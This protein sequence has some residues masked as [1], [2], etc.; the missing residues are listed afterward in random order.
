MKIFKEPAVPEDQLLL[1]PPNVADFV[2]EDAAVRIFSELVD[3][4]DCSALRDRHKGGGA[5]AY[6]PVMLFKVLVF[7]LSEGIRSSR[8]LARCLTYDV[9]FMYL[10]RMSRPDFRTIARFRKSREEAIAVLFR[11]TVL[12]AKGMGLVLL[13]HGSVDGTKLVSQASRRRYIRADELEA[14]LTKLD[15][16]IAQLL[17]EMAETDAAE[18]LE[19]G[20]GPG[21]GVPDELRNLEER[22]KRLQQAKADLA[23]QGT[24]AVVT[25]DPES[26]LMKTGDGLRPSYNAQAVVDSNVQ[27]I[28]AADVTQEAVDARQLRPM[29]ERVKSTMEELPKQVTADGGYWSKDSLDYTQEQNLDAYIA[30]AGTKENKLAGWTYDKDRDVLLSPNEEEYVYSTKRVN[31]GRTYRGYRCRKTRHLKWI[32]ND[33]DQIMRMR[34]KVATQE[35]KAIYRKRQT[36]V[37]PVFGHIKGPLGLQKLLL[38]GLTGARI[39]YLLACIAH[40]LGK[41]A[42]VRQK[43][44]AFNPA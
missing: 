33:A 43:N 7:G 15:D 12:L 36:I 24:K 14:S 10:V 26:R 28:V 42:G 32:N 18:D 23:S 11:E 8:R 37:E 1:L 9:R 35:G 6:D 30:P 17:R 31:R 3:Q 5:P 41:M 27:I 21:D 4:L 13:E 34:G 16:R 19:H 20:D 44:S 38:R 22:K 29:L 2:A 25:T 39:E 40:N